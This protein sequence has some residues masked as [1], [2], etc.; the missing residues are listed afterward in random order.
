MPR[1]NAFSS[2]PPNPPPTSINGTGSHRSSLHLPLLFPPLPPPL[3]TMARS[4][5][6]G[7][8]AFLLIASGVALLS[9]A[10]ADYEDAPAP[11]PSGPDSYL[12]QCASKLT[13]KCG[14][15][16]FG[17]IFTKETEL[18]PECCKKLVLAGIGCH[19][20]MVNFI[21]SIPTFAKNASIT[22][23]RSKQVWNQCVLLTEETLPPA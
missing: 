2:S 13:E 22:V 8:V 7:F 17:N 5:N 15:D 10:R 21:V 6:F 18:T 20:A 12:A 4:E 16:I 14:E 19:E 9:I 1:M 23:P 11:E 3:S